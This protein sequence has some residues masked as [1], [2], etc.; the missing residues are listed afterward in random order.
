MRFIHLAHSPQR[1]PIVLEK[2]KGEQS[3]SL[4]IYIP[5]HSTRS[6][7]HGANQ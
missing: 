2:G 5:T 1:A 3:F 6:L 7:R 4:S